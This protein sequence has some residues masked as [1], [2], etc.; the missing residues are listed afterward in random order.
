MKWLNLFFCL[1]HVDIVE[2]I[3]SRWQSA[4]IIIVFSNCIND[5]SCHD[6]INIIEKL[7]IIK[8]NDF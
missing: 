7:I 3:D 2:F 1:T 4:V 8:K 6:N 5:I